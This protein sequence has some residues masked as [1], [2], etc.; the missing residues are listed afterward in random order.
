MTRDS[1]QDQE[2]VKYLEEN[3]EIQDSDLACG[4]IDGWDKADETLM[5]KLKELERL[6][7]RMYTAA[8]NLTTDASQ[9]RK[10][11]EEWNNFIITKLD[12]F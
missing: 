8:Q 2:L 3:G 10:A 1:Q 11:M 12:S 9:L 7:Q 5:P 4:F 6:G